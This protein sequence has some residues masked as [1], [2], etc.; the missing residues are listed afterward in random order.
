MTFL[1]ID[2]TAGGLLIQVLLG[3][4]AGIGFIG[5]LIWGR[6]RGRSLD[7][8]EIYSAEHPTDVRPED[9]EHAA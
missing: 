4:F 9:E 6:V 3:G 5:R 1:Y 2:A 7:E 8:A